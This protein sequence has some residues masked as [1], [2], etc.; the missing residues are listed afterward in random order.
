MDHVKGRDWQYVV[1][2][3]AL[4]GTMEYSEEQQEGQAELVI[5]YCHAQCLTT[6]KNLSSDQ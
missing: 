3:K 5:P 6:S 2:D 4:G 1:R